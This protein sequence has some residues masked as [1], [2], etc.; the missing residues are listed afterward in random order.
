MTSTMFRRAP[1]ALALFLAVCVLALAAC[2]GADD[3]DD[4]AGGVGVGGSGDGAPTQEE[5]DQAEDALAAEEQ[6]VQDQLEQAQQALADALASL[7][8]CDPDVDQMT[9]IL[10]PLGVIQQIAGGD[11]VTSGALTAQARLVQSIGRAQ[12]GGSVPGLTPAQLTAMALAAGLDPTEPNW[13]DDPECASS[14]RISMEWDQS[15]GLVEVGYS[16]HTEFTASEG[17][18]FASARGPMTLDPAISVPTCSFAFLDVKTEG[19][20]VVGTLRDDVIE[21]IASIGDS[22]YNVKFECPGTEPIYVPG[23]I[24]A[25][26]MPFTLAAADGA[27]QVIQFPGMGQVTFTLHQV[28]ER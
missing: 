18:G 16:G 21:G 13:M 8:P 17:D 27:S 25:L 2:S 6:A 3:E 14:W 19:L 7:D 22:S 15:V 5:I 10:E 20:S 28:G 1:R 23:G 9:A 11:G 4:S 24:S 12:A 26:E